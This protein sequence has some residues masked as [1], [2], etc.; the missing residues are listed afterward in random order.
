M[1]A[2]TVDY[3]KLKTLFRSMT[4]TGNALTNI[5]LI[6]KVLTL[7]FQFSSRQE[8]EVADAVDHDVLLHLVVPLPVPHDVGLH[9]VADT[10]VLPLE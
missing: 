4:F 8:V 5:I 7:T 9:V 10:T 1:P 3:H 2:T 6:L